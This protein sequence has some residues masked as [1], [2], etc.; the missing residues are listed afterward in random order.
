MAVDPVCHMTVEEAEA[1]ATYDYRGERL[2]TF[3]PSRA[4]TVLPRIRSD[5]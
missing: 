1:A 2:Y 5:L 4:V 3:V